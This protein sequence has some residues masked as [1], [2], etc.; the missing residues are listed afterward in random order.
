MS[1]F[2]P[3]IGSEDGLLVTDTV[4]VAGG[5]YC[6]ILMVEAT[7]FTALTSGTMSVQGAIGDAAFAAGVVIYG[8]FTAFELFSGAVIAYDAK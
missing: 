8:N 5:N 1:H 3:Q 2:I 4:A 6:A 7:V